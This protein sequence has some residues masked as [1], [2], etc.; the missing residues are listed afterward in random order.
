MEPQ[1]S[2][3]TLLLTKWK[4]G[5]PDAFERLCRSYKAI[6][7]DKRRAQ[8]ALAAIFVEPAADDPESES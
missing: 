4:E 2:E 1:P 5:D 8:D 6:T 7:A 3:I